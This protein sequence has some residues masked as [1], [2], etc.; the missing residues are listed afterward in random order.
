MWSPRRAL[1]GLRTAVGRPLD[2]WL[3]NGGDQVTI[4]SEDCWGG[5]FCRAIGCAYTTPLAG[6]FI[7]SGDYLNFLENLRA[8]DAFDLRPLAGA[9]AYPIG[10]TPYATIHFMHAGTWTDAAEAFARRVARINRERLFF[11]IDFGKAGYTQRDVERWNRLRLPNALALLPPGPRLGF[12]FTEVHC[13]WR[14]PVWTY[15]GAAMFH[16]S[17]R[18][19]DFHHWLRT[20]ELRESRWTRA[21]N[22]LFWDRLVPSELKWRIGALFFGTNAGRSERAVRKQAPLGARRISAAALR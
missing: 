10:R 9:H 16:L 15:D 6:A 19:F 17:R 1:K 3:A 14:M 18:A 7:L 8:P 2:R 4:V 13:G 11:K 20:G 12:D 5:E 22:F 21:L